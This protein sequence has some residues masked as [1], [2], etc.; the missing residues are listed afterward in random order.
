MDAITYRQ[1]RL[2]V[3]GL[4]TSIIL[5]VAASAALRGADPVEVGAIALFVPVT[6]ILVLGGPLWGGI[7]GAIAAFGYTIVRLNTLAGADATEF[8]GSITARVLLFVAFGFLGGI[9]HRNLEQQLKKLEIYDEVDDLTGVGNARSLLS[10]ADREAARSQRYQTTFS[11]GILR[12]DTSTI[13]GLSTRQSDRVVRKF[14]GDVDRAVRTT[15]KVTRLATDDF[16]ELTVVLPETGPEGARIFIE[17]ARAGL[18]T[19]LG[20]LGVDVD[21]TTLTARW[22]TLPGDEVPLREHLARV[23]EHEGRLGETT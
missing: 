9:A 16:E 17:R 7:A 5:A 11:V 6:F 12:L 22:M 20:E 18:V 19:S 21:E 3:L 8:A 2:L 1:A 15:D 14:F 13:K 10:L 4:G 23:R